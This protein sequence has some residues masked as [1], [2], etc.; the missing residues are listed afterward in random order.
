MTIRENVA[1][2]TA[3]YQDICNK[4]DAAGRL[5]PYQKLRLDGYSH[6]DAVWVLS[7]GQD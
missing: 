1:K 4:I 3:I 7:L 5:S 6:E 2:W